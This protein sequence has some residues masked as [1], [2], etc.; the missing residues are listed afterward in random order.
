MSLW[1]TGPVH[2]EP[3]ENVSKSNCSL[4][5]VVANKKKKTSQ[6]LKEWEEKEKKVVWN[7]SGMNYLFQGH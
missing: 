6:Q 7:G 4:E 5:T 3:A 2:D 1:K